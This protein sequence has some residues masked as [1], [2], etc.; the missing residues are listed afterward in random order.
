MDPRRK[1]LQGLAL[2]LLVLAAAEIG[3]RVIAHL[4][5]R[6]RSV[7]ADPD[8]GWRYLPNVKKVGRFWG[9]DEPGSTNGQG[10]RDA[11]THLERGGSGQRLLLLGDSFTFGVL[12]D[13][14]ERFSEVIEELEPGLEA[15]NLAMNAIGPDQELRILE[16]AGVAYAPDVVVLTVFLGND[17]DD[18]RYARK[19]SHSKP[20][21]ELRDG[22]LL[23]HAPVVS[24]DERLRG[25]SYVAE[26]LMR[27]FDRGAHLSEYAPPWREADTVPLFAALVERMERV[28]REAGA[29]FL[30][31]LAHRPS[32]LAGSIDRHEDRAI[33][34]LREAG[35]SLLDTLGPFTAAAGE[36]R[37]L[38]A[39]DGHWSPAG[40]QLVAELLA[41][42]LRRRG[43]I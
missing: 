22:E 29:H 4:T 19:N 18:I 34:A 41:E 30:V 42:E 21:Y 28:S 27:P 43:W 17:L 39:S 36:A 11:E 32:R 25:T 15:V 38:F 24:W 31:I 37:Q 9:R 14:G 2:G 35:I 26:L 40:H 3:L 20:W 12:A 6:E 33:E 7:I 8:L 16:T 10:W 1:I 23:L 13:Y 5:L